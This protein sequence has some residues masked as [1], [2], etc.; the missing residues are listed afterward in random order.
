[1]E[2]EYVLEDVPVEDWL[3]V[4]SGGS[5]FSL[6]NFIAALLPDLELILVL[7][8]ANR[9]CWWV[10]VLVVVLAQFEEHRTIFI[11]IVVVA[12]VNKL[13]DIFE[14]ERDADG[15]E[16][17]FTTFLGTQFSDVVVLSS[18]LTHLRIPNLGTLTQR[19]C[20]LGS[21][22]GLF[23]GHF[24]AAEQ[25]LRVPHVYGRQQLSLR[26]VGVWL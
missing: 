2:N 4:L 13:L 8:G 3:G 11:V 16:V 24:H 12:T 25:L 19:A 15:F 5:Y 9:F 20:S 7:V 18:F 22:S 17:V 14:I 10:Q 23:F 26:R 21:S 6:E 1:L